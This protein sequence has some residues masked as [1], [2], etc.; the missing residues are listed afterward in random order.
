MK[1]LC[2]DVQALNVSVYRIEAILA[3]WLSVFVGACSA[4][5]DGETRG[6]GALLLLK[7]NWGLPTVGVVQ[8]SVWME[9]RNDRLL[10]NRRCKK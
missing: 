10:R 1:G 9:N 4:G 2:R 8:A 3:V 5:V 7:N 6:F